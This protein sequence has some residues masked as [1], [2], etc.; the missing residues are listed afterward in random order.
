MRERIDIASLV[1]GLVIIAL[2]TLLL[3]DRVDVLDLRFGWLVPALAGT[4]GAILLAGG[5]ANRSP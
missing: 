2:G 5:L 1:A 4:I 3:L